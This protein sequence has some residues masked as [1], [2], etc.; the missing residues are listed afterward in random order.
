MSRHAVITLAGN[1]PAKAVIH[2]GADMAGANS[3]R[4]GYAYHNCLRCCVHKTMAFPAISTGVMAIPGLQRQRSPLKPFTDTCPSNRC[5]KGSLS[6]SLKKCTII[7]DMAQ[8]ARIRTNQTR[9]TECAALYEVFVCVLLKKARISGIPQHGFR[10]ARRQATT[11]T[12]PVKK[13][14]VLEAICRVIRHRRAS[15]GDAQIN[16]QR[17][18]DEIGHP[19]DLKFQAMA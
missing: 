15:A 2:T 18:V 19:M 1:L 3:M 9:R 16:K 8:L 4:H 11:N 5:Q 13:P 14:S 10:R 7:S 6:V 17:C 12:S